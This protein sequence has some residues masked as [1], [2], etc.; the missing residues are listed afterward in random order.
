MSP[1]IMDNKRYN[2]KTDIWSLGCIL[3]EI[4]CLKLPFDGNSMAQLCQNIQTG[5]GGVISSSL[6]Y[7]PSLKELVKD[8]LQRN[9]TLRPG[10]NAILSRPVVKV[11]ISCFL[12]AS[13]KC[14]E[15]SHTVI[16]GM[17]ILSAPPAD[18]QSHNDDAVTGGNSNR[19]KVRVCDARNDGERVR[20][21][22]DEK[23]PKKIVIK[24]DDYFPAQHDMKKREAVEKEVRAIQ[25]RREEVLL[26]EGLQRQKKQIENG[27]KDRIVGELQNDSREESDKERQDRQ[28][29]DAEI[30]RGNEKAIALAAQQAL[31]RRRALDLEAREVSRRRC[32][33]VQPQ[34][35]AREA[36]EKR[37]ALLRQDHAGN[38]NVNL[39]P[40]SITAD[41]VLP[42]PPENPTSCNQPLEIARAPKECD[43]SAADKRNAKAR[44]NLLR[45]ERDRLERHEKLEKKAT[46]RNR[47]QQLRQNE[48]FVMPSAKQQGP[49][50][51]P[52]PLPQPPTLSS[53]VDSSKQRI[54]ESEKRRV[55]P[56]VT[57]KRDGCADVTAENASPRGM[58]VP[59]K[60]SS[61]ETAAILKKHDSFMKTRGPSALIASGAGAG[62]DDSQVS[63]NQNQRRHAEQNSPHNPI[64]AEEDACKEINAAGG[65]APD[66]H[67]S[68]FIFSGSVVPWR[69]D[70][71]AEKA[72]G[73]DAASDHR[74]E[75]SVDVA[76]E[77]SEL[78]AQ[79]Q[80]VLEDE[81]YRTAGVSAKNAP[82]R[83]TSDGEC[84]ETFGDED[85]EEEDPLYA[86]HDA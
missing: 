10:I 43:V 24:L 75:F 21:E 85:E 63:A 84:D 83:S 80:E 76:V 2:S 22:R 6:H 62:A 12:D 58:N 9:S 39:Q 73:F 48:I 30:R 57:T 11:R 40:E 50:I 3:Y 44:E 69:N 35:G 4:M 68:P 25:E 1:E 23:V 5:N 65:D 55:V 51:V 61:V 46:D 79:M 66:F 54:I 8:M 27:K 59:V 77:Y 7:S 49:A 18:Q 47:L 86:P 70:N 72:G 17:N 26:R 38:E 71:P 53:K 81:D 28:K 13:I 15:F 34:G 19:D 64:A 56:P 36:T 33:A 41:H 16:H 32:E 20:R 14:K 29:G 67:V 82:H 37:K 60:T 42:P 45:F 78:F 74:I 31:E 52:L